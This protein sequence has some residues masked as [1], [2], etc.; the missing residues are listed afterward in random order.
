MVPSVLLM[1]P[2]TWAL[3]TRR[4]TSDSQSALSTMGLVL[5][6]LT[7]MSHSLALVGTTVQ[8]PVAFLYCHLGAL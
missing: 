6:S 4:T 1:M 5:S 2:P 3:K 7:A 8:V